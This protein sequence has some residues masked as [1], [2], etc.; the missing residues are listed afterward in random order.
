MMMMITVITT[1]VNLY[2]IGRGAATL[3]S[4]VGEMVSFS[5]LNLKCLWDTNK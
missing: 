4:L 5:M 1:M 2:C 3:G